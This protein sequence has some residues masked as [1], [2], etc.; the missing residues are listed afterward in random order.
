MKTILFA[1]GLLLL[2]VTSAEAVDCGAP[3]SPSD[4]LLCSDT[5]LEALE[6]TM[7]NAIKVAL[8]NSRTQDRDVLTAN[9]Q[10][11]IGTRADDCETDQ[12]GDPATP[13]A[14]RQ[15]LFD[16][17][18]NRIK[19]LTGQPLEGPGAPDPMVPQIFAGK[20][21]AYLYAMRFVDP[22][23]PG[24][25]L[26]N[27][28]VYRQLKDIQLAKTAD[29]ISD[30]F[31]LTLQ[32]ASPKLLSAN[33]D[34]SSE[35]AQYAHP[36]PA[37]YAINV[38]LAAGK[39]LAMAD[40]LP[41]AEVKKLEAQCEGQLADYLSPHEEGAAERRD[42]VDLMV[43]DL[44]HWTFGARQAVIAY[45]DYNLEDPI[46]CTIPYDQLRPSVRPGFPLPE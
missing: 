25:K 42:N 7:G 22:K 6:N 17:T 35:G 12:T 8:D 41:A 26:F 4:K 27:K 3:A 20:D 5:Q 45:F 15:C 24:E 32:Y 21:D 36:M 28:L 11:F 9:Q 39:E 14:M 23:T 34:M 40:A 43:A 19:Y 33:I 1:L 38:D 44:S 16:E 31:K 29:D 18:G 2:A 10:S 46:T 37:V 13:D 30:Y